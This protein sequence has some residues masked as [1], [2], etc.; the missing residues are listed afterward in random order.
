MPTL[1]I[2]TDLYEWC[3]GLH[4]PAGDDG[5]RGQAE[6]MFHHLYPGLTRSAALEDT[7]TSVGRP[8]IRLLLWEARRFKDT[9]P[10][11]MAELLGGQHWVAW[12]LLWL[13][14]ALEGADPREALNS[15]TGSAWAAPGTTT[16]SRITSCSS[17]GARCWRWTPATRTRR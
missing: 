12:N 4:I 15:A 7:K 9:V 11:G 1:Y 2:Y 16:R 6:F 5:L 14:E 10:Q 3:T 13:D 17:A 8:P